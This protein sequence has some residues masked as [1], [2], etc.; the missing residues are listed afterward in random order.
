MRYLHYILSIYFGVLASFPCAD[1]A[2]H[3]E[4]ALP[5]SQAVTDATP[6]HHDHTGD[7]E[8]HCTPFC[9]CLCCGTTLTIEPPASF[10]LQAPQRLFA[11][12]T[13]LSL[14]LPDQQCVGSIFRPPIIA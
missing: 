10:R 5:V 13:D 7:E 1:T 8:D 4:A 11:G 14:D 9:A 12:V 3:A 2:L 6:A